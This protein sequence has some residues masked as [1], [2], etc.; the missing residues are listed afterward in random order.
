MNEK[1]IIKKRTLRG[2]DGHKSFTIRIKDETAEKLN[3]L[4][5]ESN[6]TRNEIIGILL[7]FAI[8]YCEIDE[9]KTND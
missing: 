9:G 5:N 4:S 8:E 6:R 1:L 7:A 2:E 3:Q